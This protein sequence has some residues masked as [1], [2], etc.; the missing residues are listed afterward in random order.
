MSA[1]KKKSDY[2]WYRLVQVFYVLLILAFVCVI[3]G[4]TYAAF[5]RLDGYS[6]SYR[7]H[8]NSGT[9]L[10][11]FEGSDLAYGYTEFETSLYQETMRF[12][13]SRPDIAPENRVDAF[14]EA[15]LQDQI[16]WKQFGS[17]RFK[18]VENPMIPK[19]KNYSIIIEDKI[20]DGSWWITFA[21]LI[22]MSMAG[23]LLALLTR[24]VFLYIAFKEPF[25][26]NMLVLRRSK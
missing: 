24:A 26:K 21:V 18:T 16:T 3:G 22:G 1:P 13:C 11:S 10:G 8:C 23:L 15:K 17:Q 19:A 12:L 25:M 20:Y 14:N 4:A 5:P 7:T 9:V 2:W 6:S